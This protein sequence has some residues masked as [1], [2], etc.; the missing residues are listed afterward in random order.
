M[1]GGGIVVSTPGGAD[2]G[3]GGSFP[4]CGEGE[5]QYACLVEN[6]ASGVIAGMRRSSAIDQLSM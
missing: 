6:N 1:E 2:R 4:A 3:Q 5:P